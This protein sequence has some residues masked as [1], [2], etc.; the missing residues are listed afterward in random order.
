[1]LP[2]HFEGFH[3]AEL[4][5]VERFGDRGN[6]IVTLRRQGRGVHITLTDAVS[7]IR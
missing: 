6:L 7:G 4:H 5:A 1:M 2:K 3:Q